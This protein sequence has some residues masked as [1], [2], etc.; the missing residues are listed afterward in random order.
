MGEAG[1]LQH[2]ADGAYRWPRHRWMRG[3]QFDPQFARTPMPM[4]PRRDDVRLGLFANLVGP[5]MR[6]PA[7]IRQSRYPFRLMPRQPLIHRLPRYPVNLG[8]R[9]DA[10]TLF[11]FFDQSDTLVHGSVFLPRHCFLACRPGTQN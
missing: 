4:L 3:Y 5:G 6:R 2:F 9:R 1:A 7:S 11:V 8:Q 10:F